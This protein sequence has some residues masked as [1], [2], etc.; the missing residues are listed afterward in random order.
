M[1]HRL[2]RRAQ[3][4]SV[5]SVLGVGPT[6]LRGRFCALLAVWGRSPGQSDPLFSQEGVTAET[7]VRSGLRAPVEHL[8]SPVLLVGSGFRP[9]C[10]QN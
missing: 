6:P 8:W 7:R 9:R 1:I 5:M 4:S 3:L 10:A 2:V